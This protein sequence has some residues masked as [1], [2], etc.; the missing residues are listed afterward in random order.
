MSG[1]RHHIYT[2][3]KLTQKKPALWTDARHPIVRPWIHSAEVRGKCHYE[4]GNITTTRL[5]NP[6]LRPAVPLRFMGNVVLRLGTQQQDCA[7]KS[8]RKKKSKISFKEN[9]TKESDN[10]KICPNL[11][12]CRLFRV[13]ILVSAIGTLYFFISLK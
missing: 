7:K 12:I 3:Q 10:Q 9:A 2:V 1:Q 11:I 4:N 6:V 13:F 5:R 8:L